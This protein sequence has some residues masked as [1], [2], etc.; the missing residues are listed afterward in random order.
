MGEVRVHSCQDPEE[1]QD[2][3]DTM[4]DQHPGQGGEPRCQRRL[5]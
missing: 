4:M 5:P 1:A 3:Q 2:W